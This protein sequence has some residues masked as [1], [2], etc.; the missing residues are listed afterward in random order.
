[1]VQMVELE[2]CHECRER[3]AFDKNLRQYTSLVIDCVVA[4]IHVCFIVGYFACDIQCWYLQRIHDVR[5]H[6]Y[7]LFSCD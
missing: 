7:R 5:G 4:R 2:G 6:V 3:L 1:M